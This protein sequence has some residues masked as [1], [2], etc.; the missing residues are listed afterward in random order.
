M[1]CLSPIVEIGIRLWDCSSKHMAY[2]HNFEENLRKLQTEKEDLNRRRHDVRRMVEV[3]EQQPRMRRTEEAEEWLTSAETLENEVNVIIQEG[4]QEL[5]NKCVGNCCT[6]NLNSTYKIGKRIIK[7]IDSVKKKLRKGEPFYSDSAIVVKLPRLRLLMPEWPLQNTVGVSFAVERVWKCIEDEN[8]R[9]IRLCGVGGVGKTTL[10]KKVSNEFHRQ[11]HDFDTVIWAKVPRHEDYIDKVQEVVRKKLDIPDAVWNQC[12]GEDE[13]GAQIFSVLNGKKFV[14]LLDD[15]W[16]QF[17][18]L[19]LGIHLRNDQN[20]SK[21]IFTA[22][23]LGLY[24][25]MEA[26]V[27]IEVECLPP[28]EALSLFRM[29]VGES[30]LSS[31]PDLSELANTFA[32]RCGGLPLAL[33][34]VAGAMACRKNLRE[35]RHS[36]DLLHTNPSEIAGMGAYVFP[37]LKLSYDSLNDAIAQNCF[38]YCSIFPEDYNIGIDEIIDLWIGEG[39]LDGPNPCDRGAFIVGTLKLAYLLESDESKRWV[40]MHDII[41]HMALW[42]ARD[43]GKNKNK[44]LVA[45]SGRITNHELTNWEEANW[46]SLFGS[47]RVNIEYSPSCHYLST[48]IFRDGQLESFPTGFFDN[49][50]HLKV[51]DLSGNQRLVE[52]PPDIGNVKILQYL[53]LSSTSI[54]KVPTGLGNFRK[55]RCLLLDYTMNLKWIPKEVISNLLMLQV[56]SRINQVSYFGFA[57]VVPYDEVG[58]LEVLE[59]LDHISKIGITIFAAPSLE[60]ILKSY[61]LRSCIRTLKLIECT[62]LVS[63]YF[64]EDLSNLER[65]ELFHCGSIKEFKV[66]ERCE[67]GNLSTVHIEVC[68]LLLNLNF[69]AHARNLEILSIVDCELLKEVTIEEKAFPRLKSIS[70]TRLPNLKIICPSPRRFLSL[71]EIEVYK[72]P[73]MRQLPFCLQSANF[74]QKIGGEAEWWDGLIWDDEAVK[75]ACRLK[76]VS[77]PFKRLAKTSSFQRTRKSVDWSP[78]HLR[79]S[80]SSIGVK[81]HCR[82]GSLK[83]SNHIVGDKMPPRIKT[84]EIEELNQFNLE[85]MKVIKV[86][87]TFNDGI[88]QLVQHKWSGQFFALK[89]IQMNMEESVRK[90]IAE[91]FKISASSECPYVVVCHQSF[92][93]NGVIS[94]ILEYM[95]GGSL[96]GFLKKVKSIPEP[97]LAAICK[98][99]LKGL[100][101]LHSEAHV[102][103]R[104]IKPSNLLINYRGEVKITDFRVSARLLSTSGRANTFVGTYC[105]MSPE[106]IVGGSYD[107]TAD[108]WSLGL[109]LLECAIGR[110]PYTPPEQAERWTNSYELMEEIVEQPPPFAP[111]DQ[112]SSEFCSFISACL[113][114]DPKKRKSSHELLALPFLN[115]YNNLDVDLSSYF[116]NAGSPVAN[117]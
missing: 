64:R 108:I 25:D 51:L 17:D 29:T 69:L 47:S 54:A 35:W 1:D 4:Y 110:F 75:D 86:I 12:S 83:V 20:Q 84:F 66:S 79:R 67:L 104:D 16:E 95:D 60:K 63:P 62:D 90:Q 38:L 81:I 117:F 109:L 102:I 59:C 65:L 7:K 10:M 8:I 70:L 68:P 32:R 80:S 94:L 76:F 11:S 34:T 57:E 21:V 105:Y 36:F 74:L 78:N 100:M 27:T 40:R 103:H 42:L 22:R 61:I 93:C 82:N 113:Q 106:R 71:L 9:I 13:K 37:L 87:G 44:V 89:I 97:Y 77:P 3:A 48:L 73:S 72:C 18:L 24:F 33:L 114:K 58:F 31:D 91:E 46:I 55:L 19:R 49:M 30:I 116:S 15:V 85:D 43:Q 88:V 41:R 52:L 45:K 115:M 6:K 111:S 39:F 101:Y 98:Q 92:Y 107:I 56:Y 26:Q 96:A 112:F 23:S 14:L 2:I 50:P 99:V 5:Q 28:E 53:N